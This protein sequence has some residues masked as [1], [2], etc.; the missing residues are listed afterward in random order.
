MVYFCQPKLVYRCNFKAKKQRKYAVLS[1][2][3]IL[4]LF[5][6]CK[7]KQ[8]TTI[9][10]IA[11]QNKHVRTFQPMHSL[12][13]VTYVIRN[14]FFIK[15]FQSIHS[16]RSVTKDKR[17][18]HNFDKTISIHTLLTEC[19]FNGLKFLHRFFISIHTLL[20]ECNEASRLTSQNHPRFNPYTPY[21][22]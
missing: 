11:T 16:L 21:G 9:E 10:Y 14:A 20:T 7:R 5:H 2:I 18:A 15:L 1:I 22:V 6:W 17:E 8:C 19:N 12:R 13:S 3:S 4:K